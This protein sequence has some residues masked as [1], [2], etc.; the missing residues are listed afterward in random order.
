MGFVEG[1]QRRRADD[2]NDHRP[3]SRTDGSNARTNR[4]LVEFPWKYQILL[5]APGAVVPLERDR[6]GKYSELPLRKPR[7]HGDNDEVA[8]C[9]TRYRVN[10][11]S[12]RACSSSIVVS[13]FRSIFVVHPSFPSISVIFFS[14][15]S[16]EPKN[17]KNIY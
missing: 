10:L 4:E 6:G 14:P 5:T 1:G 12:A 11:L 7:H 3:A 17:R 8:V 9:P 2:G 15:L 13:S 16:R